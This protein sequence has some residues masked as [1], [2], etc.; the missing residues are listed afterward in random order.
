M[1]TKYLKAKVS[2]AS[3]LAAAFS[4][5]HNGKYYHITIYTHETKQERMIKEI[6]KGEYD[7]LNWVLYEYDG[8]S[9]RLY[10]SL[11]TFDLTNPLNSL[12]IEMEKT[13]EIKKYKYLWERVAEWLHFI[14]IKIPTYPF[15][16][17]YD[18]IKQ[19][20]ANSQIIKIA[21]YPTPSPPS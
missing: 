16:L 12:M 17:L 14:I 2:R 18:T 11:S 9:E 3:E 15:R 4:F 7:Q 20:S 1:T 5:E 13:N 19:I 8:Q 6:T 21:P 10:N